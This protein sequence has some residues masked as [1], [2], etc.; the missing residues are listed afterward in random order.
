MAD[1]VSHFAIHAD[2]LDRAI[3]FY[4]AVFGWA[5]QAWGPPGFYQITNAGLPGALHG[6]HAPALDNDGHH[7]PDAAGI[8]FRRQ[9]HSESQQDAGAAQP[10]DPVLHRA[11]RD[12]QRLGEGRSGRARIGAQQGDEAVIEVIHCRIVID[13]AQIVNIRRIFAHCYVYSLARR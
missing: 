9:A 11:P 4:S 3:A 2:D 7:R 12:P 6:R 13:P 1:P 5:F 10:V 8:V